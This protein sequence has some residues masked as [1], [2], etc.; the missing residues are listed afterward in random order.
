VYFFLQSSSVQ[1]DRVYMLLLHEAVGTSKCW[2]NSDV[3]HPRCVSYNSKGLRMEIRSVK[4]SNILTSIINIIRCQT[5]TCFGPTCGPSS[6]CNL[7][8]MKLCRAAWEHKCVWGGYHGPLPP[9]HYQ[10]LQYLFGLLRSL[11][12]DDL[13]LSV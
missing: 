1:R 10:T 4:H 8:P 12:R 13:C 5:T 7:R 9:S 6:G 11:V 3:R 2:K